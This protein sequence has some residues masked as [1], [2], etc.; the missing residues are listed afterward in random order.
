[1][2]S[3][4]DNITFDFVTVMMEASRKMSPKSVLYWARKSAD[5]AKI[6]KIEDFDLLQPVIRAPYL[7]PAIGEATRKELWGK[8]LI[9]S[10]WKD[11]FDNVI[12]EIVPATPAVHIHAT[13]L[14][15]PLRTDELFEEFGGAEILRSSAF[16]YAQIA[17]LAKRHNTQ[18]V[19][20]PIIY[21]G[22]YNLFPFITSSGELTIAGLLSPTDM[23]HWRAYINSVSNSK[24]CEG[25]ILTKEHLLETILHF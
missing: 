6:L 21:R 3:T 14:A 11:H 9:K 12:P 20:E 8:K 13:K 22:E 23:Y 18:S 15:I 1:M 16:T 2:K 10:A 7:L 19:A 24:I 17:A 5:L 4:L 25:T